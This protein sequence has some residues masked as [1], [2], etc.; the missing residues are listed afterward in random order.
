[1]MM[2]VSMGLYARADRIWKL[3]GKSHEHAV[4]LL[5]ETTELIFI[6]S[7]GKRKLRVAYGSADP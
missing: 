3:H 4:L 1:M 6:A 5:G 7:M 2:G